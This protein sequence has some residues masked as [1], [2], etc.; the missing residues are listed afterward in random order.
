[1]LHFICSFYRCRTIPLP[2]W[3]RCCPRL[4]TASPA[5]TA[6]REPGRAGRAGPDRLAQLALAGRGLAAWLIAPMGASAVLLFCLPASPLAQPWA[7]I[8][9]NLVSA[10][11][12]VACARLLPDPLLAALA[13]GMAW[14]SPSCSRCAACIR[15]AGRWP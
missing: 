7:V 8:G 11:V 6:A 15:R 5:R 14:P 2:G 9:G 1:M 3:A 10:L 12:G 13:G 4:N